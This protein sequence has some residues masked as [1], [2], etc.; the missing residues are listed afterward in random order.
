MRDRD[1]LRRQL[2]SIVGADHVLDPEPSDDVDW[3]GRYQGDASLVVRPGDTAEVAKV[4]EWARRRGV[5]LV[6]QGGNTGLVGGSIARDGA[7]VVSTRRLRALGPVDSL[8]RQVTVGA[9]VTLQQ[10]HEHVAPLGLRYPVD[11]GARGSATI[12]GS[13]ATNAGGINVVRYGMTRRQIVGI[14]AVLGTGETIS[15]LGGLVKDNTGFDLGG[16]LCGSEGTLGIVTAV[17]VQLVPKS[18][19]VVTA[20]VSCSNVARAV[21]VAAAVCARLD[22]VDA[23]E[24]VTRDGVELVRRVSGAEISVPDVAAHVLIECSS[25][26]DQSEVLSAV[27]ASFDDVDVSVAVTSSHRAQL[28][29][30]REDQTP[31]I[32]TLGVPIK[33]DVTVPLSSLGEFIEVIPHLVSDVRPGARTFVFGHVADGNM[34]VNV[35]GGDGDDGLLAGVVL[36]EVVGRGGSISAEH[37]IG[38]AKR[39]WLHLVRSSAEI[40]SMRAIKRA[41]DPGGILN[42]GVLLP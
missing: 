7:V 12:G 40:E 19:H 22:C 8:S 32:N 27:L 30:L 17:R 29:R 1:E 14:E 35:V 6:P 33:F 26:S 4:V 24:L 41:L 28:W 37:G 23:A 13:V 18:P 31:S 36:G 9:G 38:V 2:G 39:A 42:P 11:F 34:H 16:L 21:E 10:M 25:T 5:A 15:H 20:L 3:T